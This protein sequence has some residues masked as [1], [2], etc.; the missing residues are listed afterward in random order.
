M[1][2]RVVSSFSKMG[3]KLFLS[4]NSD[5]PKLRLALMQ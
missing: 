2:P 4:E 5:R 1:V 3:K